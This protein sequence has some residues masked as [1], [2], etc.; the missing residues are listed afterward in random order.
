MKYKFSSLCFVLLWASNET[1]TW[2]QRVELIH[3]PL[4]AEFAADSNNVT[5]V[6]GPY[7]SRIV[8]TV[9]LLV[10]HWQYFCSLNNYN[11]ISE[12]QHVLLDRLAH[13]AIDITNKEADVCPWWAH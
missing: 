8:A 12:T 1:N 10:I 2:T 4:A 13:S 3:L 5:I 7:N 6:N 11:H 9:K